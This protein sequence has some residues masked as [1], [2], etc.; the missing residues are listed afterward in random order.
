MTDKALPRW[1]PLALAGAIAFAAGAWLFSRPPAP[2]E[3]AARA[4][5]TGSLRES[6]GAARPQTNRRPTRVTEP[7]ADEPEAL[8]DEPVA[9]QGGT[10]GAAATLPQP[11][12]RGSI[13]DTADPCDPLVEPP[14]PAA[15]ER[16]T[17]AGVTIAWP[18]ELTAHEPTGLAYTVAGLLREA[19]N[20]TGTEPRARLT[21]F[22]YAS[23]DEL[24]L[25]TGT[26]EWASGVYDGAV[27]VV[28]EPSIDFGVRV[29]TLRHEVMHAQ[30][31]TGVGCMPA[32]FNEGAAQL[33]AGRP[34][35]A[36][37]M[38]MLKE[39]A[40]FDFDALGAPTIAEAP[41][42]DA[43]KLYAESLAMLLHV[44]DRPSQGG[45]AEV[46]QSLHEIDVADPELRARTL[47]RTLSPSTTPS[48]V[49]AS[50]AKRLFGVSSEAD[51][52]ALFAGPVCCTG[53]RRLADLSCRA[54]GDA[55]PR[56]GLDGGRA[57]GA[58]RCRRY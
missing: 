43:P 14:I 5:D 40:S 37:W 21:V 4:A 2:T 46:V 3:A 58:S 49:R 28:E 51:L 12:L 9:R 45:L 24:H 50:L 11:A 57:T 44:I 16:V 33:F 56:D 52:D 19:A 15:F 27:H 35:V 13:L 20:A 39:R 48:H 53:E 41:K 38:T 1:A 8:D 18:L 47:W 6:P 32:W 34:P 31:H 42:D 17:E 7:D 30:L 25:A 54:D 22:L 26:P 29:S 23:R 36:T 10:A 55:S